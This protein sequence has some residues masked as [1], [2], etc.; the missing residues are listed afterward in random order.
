MAYDPNKDRTIAKIGSI[1][2][3]KDAGGNPSGKLNFKIKEYN[4]KRK[5]AITYWSTGWTGD[6]EFESAKVPRMN[7]EQV[8]KCIE[9][10][11][12]LLAKAWDVLEN[13]PPKKKK[14]S[15]IKRKATKKNE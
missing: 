13:G 11:P 3:T 2:L 14:K 9:K 4:G 12:K 1:T 10:M 7:H 8:E 6:K 5:L 15:K